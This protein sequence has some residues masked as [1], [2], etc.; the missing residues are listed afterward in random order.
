MQKCS[1]GITRFHDFFWKYKCHQNFYIRP[2][3]FLM[4]AYYSNLFLIKPCMLNMSATSIQCVWSQ[5]M[6]FIIDTLFTY[7]K[8]L[9][10]SYFSPHLPMN[11]LRR[12]YVVNCLARCYR[13]GSSSGRL[14]SNPSHSEEQCMKETTQLSHFRLHLLLI[15]QGFVIWF[16]LHHST[17]RT[18]GVTLW[19]VF[20]FIWGRWELLP[21]RIL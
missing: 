15:S 6:I 2:P 18:A 9:R 3:A 17:P 13:E 16:Q 8:I 7:L 10:T 12:F 14:T 21:T 5:F 11:K 19:R 1:S 20:Y 4:L